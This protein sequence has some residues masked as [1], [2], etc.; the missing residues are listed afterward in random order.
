MVQDKTA[1][2]GYISYE[3][4]L[5]GLIFKFPL[6]ASGRDTWQI[7]RLLAAAERPQLNL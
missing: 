1:S 7:F 3:I 2:C 6:M 4:K 5:L